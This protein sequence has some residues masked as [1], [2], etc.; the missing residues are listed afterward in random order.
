MEVNRR[1][2]LSDFFSNLQME[3][4]SYKVRALIYAREFDVQKFNAI[5]SGKR[6][7]IEQIAY[8]NKLP[9]IFNSKQQQ[10]KYIEK[11]F[12]QSGLPDF[13][14]RDDYQTNVKGKWDNIYFFEKGKSVFLIEEGV[15]GTIVKLNCSNNQ[16]EVK[17]EGEETFK[18]SAI[19]NI[20]RIFSEDFFE[21]I[22]K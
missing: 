1:I 21:K 19:D 10:E 5:C 8:R 17:I 4:I 16:V 7:K 9:S 15:F 12:G 3:Y 6:E 22:F 2:C 11:F 14:Y 13:K 18:L 20:R